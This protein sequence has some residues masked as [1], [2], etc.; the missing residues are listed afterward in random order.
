MPEVAIAL[1][2]GV[3]SSV[4]A[5]LLA[6]S[7]R[8]VFGVTMRLGLAG[9][10]GR[11]CCG[12]EE[13]LLARRV[14]ATLGIP[15]TVIDIAEEFRAEVVGPF[16]RAYAQG[17]TPNPCVWCN[18]RVKFGS[19]VERVRRLGA[20][21]LATG[22]YAQLVSEGDRVWLERARDRA[23]DQSYFLYRI[24]EDVLRMLEFPVGGLLKTDVRR[25]AEAR[26]LPTAARR[27][28]QEVCFTDDHVALVEAAQPGANA[29]GPIEDTDGVALGIHRGIA[30]YT[31]G[32]RKGL[33]IG[34]SGG[35]YRVVR[36][37]AARC[38]VIVAPEAAAIQSEAELIEAVWRLPARPTPVLA[39][40]RYRA[41]PVNAVA[42]PTD[43]GLHVTF[44]RATSVLAPG[45]SLVLYAGDRV[46]GGGIIA[47]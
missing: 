23:K 25:M 14:C 24:P 22:H 28:S 39:Q 44:E 31:V 36:I 21:T 16:C 11:P 45:Q 30:R 18:E 42:E 8:D 5:A 7:G 13:M 9:I 1:S 32:Q 34:G 35:P 3:D 12:E 10:G 2:G 33:G 19:F 47:H 27:D 20:T 46:V 4:A 40:V 29:P 17:L 38:A 43:S 15:H 41:R 26:G 37:D 6:E